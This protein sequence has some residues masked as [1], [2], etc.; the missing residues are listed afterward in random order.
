MKIETKKFF[1]A[2]TLVELL[3]VIAII[4]YLRHTDDARVNVGA[5][6]GS[7]D[8]HNEQRPPALSGCNLQIAMTA[9]QPA[10]PLR[11]TPQSAVPR[12]ATRGSR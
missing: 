4:S 11:R 6:Q 8:R 5:V 3:V 2:F 9:Q 7:T 10:T 1:S 12:Q